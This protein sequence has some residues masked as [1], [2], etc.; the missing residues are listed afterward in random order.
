MTQPGYL[1]PIVKHVAHG[2]KI[3]EYMREF[4]Q[5]LSKY[6]QYTVGE[7]AG[8]NDPK[9]LL[10][11]IRPENKELNT[12]FVSALSSALSISGQSTLKHCLLSFE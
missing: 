11:Y 12:V 7:T 8:T 9:V 2:P 5:V 6:D 1:Q 4:G 3:H 10:E